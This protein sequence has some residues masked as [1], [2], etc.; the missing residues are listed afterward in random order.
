MISVMNARVY[1]ETT[2]PSYLT[3]WPSR[4]LVRAAHQ[5]T[6]REWWGRRQNYDL[7]ISQLVVRECQA[8]DKDAA[9]ERLVALTGLPLREQSEAVESLA[10]AAGPGTAPGTGDGGCPAHRH[11]GSARDGLPADVEL[12]S[13][14]ERD[15]PGADRGC[16]PGREVRAAGDLHTGGIAPRRRG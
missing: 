13:Y 6:T 14:C 9:L 11:G 5:Q 1:L 12:H 10:G 2:I 4:D 7:F 15:P 3:A 8:G 16:M